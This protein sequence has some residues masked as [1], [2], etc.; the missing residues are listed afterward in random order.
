MGLLRASVPD[1]RYAILR[2]VALLDI[3]PKKVNRLHEVATLKALA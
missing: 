3:K 1:E 2:V